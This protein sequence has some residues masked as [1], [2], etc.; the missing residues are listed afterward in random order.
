MTR[1]VRDL[2]EEARRLDPEG[3]A[4]VMRLVLESLDADW[5]KASTTPAWRE[6]ERRM[7]WQS[8]TLVRSSDFPGTS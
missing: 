8:L 6:V 7:A 1:S 5:R 4:I 2:L 3:H